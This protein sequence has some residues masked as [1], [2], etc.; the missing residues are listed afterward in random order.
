MLIM[1]QDQS[2]HKLH[3]TRHGSGESSLYSKQ[4]RCTATKSP[5]QLE[6]CLLSHCPSPEKSIECSTIGPFLWKISGQRPRAQNR[7]FGDGWRF[8]DYGARGSFQAREAAS[9]SAASAS[10]QG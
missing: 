2:S 3:G 9:R 10:L 8:P 6:K 1:M 4:S 5:M 7:N